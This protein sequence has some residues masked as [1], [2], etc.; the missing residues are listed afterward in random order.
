MGFFKENSG[1]LTVA[2]KRPVNLVDVPGTY[3]FFLPQCVS[4]V[5]A[6]CNVTVVASGH[7]LLKKFWLRS[8]HCREFHYFK[9][10]RPVY[11]IPFLFILLV[12]LF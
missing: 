4:L 3:S 7:E 8:T 1:V 2:G 9:L 6:V 10:C 5:V 11:S 12:S